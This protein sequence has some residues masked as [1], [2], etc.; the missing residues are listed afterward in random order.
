M[1]ELTRSRGFGADSGK[2]LA[3]LLDSPRLARYVA[4][5][6]PVALLQLVD[7]VGLEDA[8]ELVALCSTPQLVAMLDEDSWRGERAGEEERFEPRRFLVW[9]EVLLEAGDEFAAAR[10]AALSFDFVTLA[11]S[12]L[13]LV[14]NVDALVEEF[15][16]AG[17]EADR[18]EKALSNCVC[19]ELDE[20]QLVAR[21]SE[22]W[23]ALWALLLALDR[24]HREF[25][26]RVL[27]RCC[28]L[29]NRTVDEYGGLY[30]ALTNEEMLESDAAGEREVRRARFGY[31]AATQAK[32]FLGLATTGQGEPSQRDPV[33]RAYF[34][35][36]G[37]SQAALNKP[38]PTTRLE[39]ALR[40]H[41]PQ[42]LA[43]AHGEVGTLLAR[44]LGGADAAL[45]A[46]RRDEL[47]YLANV[48]VAG[49][50]L[51][52]RRFRPVEA[53]EAAIASVNLELE[54]AAGDDVEAARCVLAEQP[55]VVL[56][57]RALA[58]LQTELGQLTGPSETLPRLPHGAGLGFVSTRAELAA[59]KQTSAQRA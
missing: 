32:A 49:A 14:L 1:T 53:L 15:D 55:A 26:R 6:S 51:E 44:A 54:F 35:E 47:A 41:Q 46:A 57:R 40:A 30:E 2:L 20:F 50:T 33:T 39:R 17:E 13:L 36:A 37:T 10:V 56:F 38:R 16:G 8:G 28:D 24:D 18:V 42:A 58:R 23:D 4:Q 21:S 45:V 11:L 19:E 12:K 52:G 9:L 7:R 34:R 25:L 3:R 5:A 43:Q 22:G 29:S 59:A 27:E 31:I 48:L